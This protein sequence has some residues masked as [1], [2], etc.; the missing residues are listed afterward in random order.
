MGGYENIIWLAIVFLVLLGGV[1]LYLFVNQWNFQRFDHKYFIDHEE[2]QNRLEA[3]I[4]HLEKLISELKG[5]EQ[6]KR[7]ELE[8]FV[9]AAKAEIADKVREAQDEI[10]GEVI[11][12]PDMLDRMLMNQAL[13]RQSDA[14][15]HMPVPP[16]TKTPSRSHPALHNA[17]Q[18]QVA[19]LLEQGFTHSEVA[20]STGVSGQEI[21]MVASIIFDTR[22]A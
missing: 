12:Q 5:F 22:S 9:M 18:R 8:Y 14:A 7:E 19:E 17:R 21:E 3:R 6:S 20:K 4:E 2:Q 16:R 1:V 15:P 10:V 13:T 11:N